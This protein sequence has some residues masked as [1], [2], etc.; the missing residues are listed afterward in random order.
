MRLLLDTHALIWAVEQP[1]RIGAAARSVLEDAS[2]ELLVSAASIWET[3]I[4][5]SLGKL[6]L[7]LPYRHWMTQA[8]SDLGAVVLPITIDC[9]ETQSTLPWR[10]RD[11]FDRMLAS[12][13]LV[14][15]VPLVSGDEVFD[16]YGVQ[17]MWD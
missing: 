7:A 5:V 3:S 14:E 12:Q 11:P 15:Q 8:I 4:K 13:A 2:N 10:H 16:Q 6:S 9:A 1:N 17:R